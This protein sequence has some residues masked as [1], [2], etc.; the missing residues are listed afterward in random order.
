MG[1]HAHNNKRLAL[2]NTILANSLGVNWL[3]CTI[4]GM[5]QELEIL[6]Q[7]SY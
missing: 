6:L 7:R 4:T 2:K 5:G 1:I 3:D